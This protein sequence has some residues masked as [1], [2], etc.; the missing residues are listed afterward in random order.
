MCDSVICAWLA[1]GEQSGR[2]TAVDGGKI[3]VE[4]KAPVFKLPWRTRLQEEVA[5]KVAAKGPT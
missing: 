5:A 2:V 3:A 4:T 1:G